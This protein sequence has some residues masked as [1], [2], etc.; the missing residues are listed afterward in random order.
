MTNKKE[1]LLNEGTI[2]RF[3]TLANI[4]SLSENF[5]ADKFVKEEEEQS[6]SAGDKRSGRPFWVFFV[7]CPAES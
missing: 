2:R 1:K 5:V 3:M 6:A 4:D 7:V